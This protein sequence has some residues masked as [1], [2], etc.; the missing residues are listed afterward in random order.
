MPAQRLDAV[1]NLQQFVL[2]REIHQPFNEVEA[3]TAHARSMQSLQFLIRHAALNGGHTACLATAGH[4]S[5]HHRTIVCAVASGLH[6]H[7]PS[8]TQMIAQR[9]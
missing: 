8:K 5:I 3:H 7:I 4:A 2:W 9:I 1:G 6:D